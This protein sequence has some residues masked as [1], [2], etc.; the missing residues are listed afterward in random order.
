M[1]L[2]KVNWERKKKKK[3]ETKKKKKEKERKKRNIGHK[4]SCDKHDTK[5]SIEEEKC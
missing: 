5:V 4:I 1:K 2:I 3:R